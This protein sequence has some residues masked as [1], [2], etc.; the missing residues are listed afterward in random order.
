[1]TVKGVV[2]ISTGIVSLIGSMFFVHSYFATAGELEQLKSYTEYTFDER[3]LENIEDKMSVI[4]IKPENIRQEW[5]KE[6]LLMLQS[7]Q[8]RIIRRIEYNQ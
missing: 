3:K 2:S 5:E 7:Q 1:M 6:K 8:K 4:L